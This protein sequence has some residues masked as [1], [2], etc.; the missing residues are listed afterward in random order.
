MDW[1]TLMVALALVMI[2]EGLLPFLS[3]HRFRATLL[4]AATLSNRALRIAGLVAMLGGLATLYW[5]HP[6]G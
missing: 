2:I 3:P 1:N 4:T 5:V 6:A